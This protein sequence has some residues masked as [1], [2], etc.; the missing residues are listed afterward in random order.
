MRHSLRA[1][2]LSW[3]ILLVPILAGSPTGADGNRVRNKAPIAKN[4]VATTAVDTSVT[5]PV[6]ANDRDRDG[7]IARKTVRIV[8]AGPLNGRADKRRNGTVVYTPNPGFSG[9][10]TP[11]AS[12][13]FP[14]RVRSKG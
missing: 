2:P 8:G 9:Q 14:I 13:Q 1:V 7:G 11:D 5:I 6:T 3:L 4:D 10:D 12:T